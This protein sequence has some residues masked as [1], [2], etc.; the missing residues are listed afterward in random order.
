[1]RLTLISRKKPS[2]EEH[3]RKTSVTC[4][5]TS[6]QKANNDSSQL[7]IMNLVQPI[8]P[9]LLGTLC[10]L[11]HRK[12]KI[13]TRAHL[14]TNQASSAICR[15][16][17]GGRGGRRFRRNRALESQPSQGH[18]T[19]HKNCPDGVAR[20]K[21]S[22]PLGSCCSVTYFSMSI[23][24]APWLRKK[25]RKSGI[26]RNTTFQEPAITRQLSPEQLQEKLSLTPT[27]QKK[28]KRVYASEKPPTFKYF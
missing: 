2:R 15:G 25:Y 4:F 12:T 14:S 9:L 23:I 16:A 8:W 24:L 26:A 22:I 1:M 17:G 11:P 10:K 18:P 20:E 7:G 5:G 3:V 27:R 13:A 6:G 19:W 21:K 28:K